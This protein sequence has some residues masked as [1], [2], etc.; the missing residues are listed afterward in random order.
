MI[1]SIILEA[2]RIVEDDQQNDV[3]EKDDSDPF[4][5]SQSSK[6]SMEDNIDDEI[7]IPTDDELENVSDDEI[8]V[9]QLSTDSTDELLNVPSPLGKKR[10]YLKIN[11]VL[12]RPDEPSPTVMT[13]AVLETSDSQTFFPE[14]DQSSEPGDNIYDFV[15]GILARSVSVF[16]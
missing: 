4:Q 5:V 6:I 8:K 15:E 7:S 12:A 9:R 1:N 3:S 2:T 11:L 13:P 16:N 10:Q 14:N